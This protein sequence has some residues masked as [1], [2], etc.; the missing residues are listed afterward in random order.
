MSD[1][2]THP[3]GTGERLAKLEE[4]LRPFADYADHRARLPDTFPIT[5]GS[6]MAKRQLT[7]GDCYR[8][9]DMLDG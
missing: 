1:F 8:A 2:E 4:A 3:A 5:S 7:M 9:K 6:P